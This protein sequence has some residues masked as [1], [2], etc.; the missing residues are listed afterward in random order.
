MHFIG[1]TKVTFAGY[2]TNICRVA[3]P[4]TTTG[5]CYTLHAKDMAK[6]EKKF[7]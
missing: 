2:H 4:A 1:Q 5:R 6:I 3:A 7:P